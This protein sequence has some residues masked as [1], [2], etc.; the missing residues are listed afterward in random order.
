MRAADYVARAWNCMPWRYTARAA[1]RPDP[2]STAYRPWEGRRRPWHYQFFGAQSIR[3]AWRQRG[4]CDRADV[5]MP[6]RP[7]AVAG[8]RNNPRVIRP[9]VAGRPALL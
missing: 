8:H 7:A 1:W 2:A 6:W 5:T 4:H 9:A 3:R